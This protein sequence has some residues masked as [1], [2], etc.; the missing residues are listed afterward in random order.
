MCV[1][2]PEPQNK[3]FHDEIMELMDTCKGYYNNPSYGFNNY[4][5]DS[6]IHS[7]VL[8]SWQYCPIQLLVTASQDGIAIWDYRYNDAFTCVNLAAMD[9]FFI[10]WARKE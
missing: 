4:R 5:S 9:L 6:I 1:D 8:H 10:L 3:V 7:S 2:S